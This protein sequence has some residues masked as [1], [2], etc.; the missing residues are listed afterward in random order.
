VLQM[1]IQF[2]MSPDQKT[3]TS[4]KEPD[5]RLQEVE[6]CTVTPLAGH[7]SGQAHIE[8]AKFQ[9]QFDYATFKTLKAH[10]EDFSAIGITLKKDAPVE[11]FDRA[12]KLGK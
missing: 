9:P 10:Q 5:F 12:W 4:F 2:K 3:V 8:Y 7:P 6:R 11:N 1:S